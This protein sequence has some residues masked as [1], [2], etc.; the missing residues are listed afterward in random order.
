MYVLRVTLK[1]LKTV[2]TSTR[3]FI[4]W[5]ITWC[6]FK[7]NGV[8][9]NE[10]KANGYPVINVNLSGLFNIG[11]NVMINSSKYANPIGRQQQCFFVV[12]AGAHL[13]IGDNVGISSSAIVC[14][15]KISIGDNVKIGGNVVIYDTDFHS[16]SSI[17]RNSIPE[18]FDHTIS[19]PVIIEDNVFI[20]AHS[21]IL[22]GV[23]VGHGS[24]IGACS[25]VAKNIPSNE[26]WAGNPARFLSKTVD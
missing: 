18:S 22:K 14:K 16:L 13:S 17:Y 20:G 8:K 7:L 23:T 2:V 12:G 11:K 21:C 15:T 6:L 3:C 5:V 9:F 1:V 25:V 24:I 10:F 26:I 19:K 4:S